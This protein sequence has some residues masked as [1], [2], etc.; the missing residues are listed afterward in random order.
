MLEQRIRVFSESLARTVDRR[1]FL[2]RTGSSIAAGVAALAMGSVLTKSQAFAE[3]KQPVLSPTI[4]CAPP[5]PYC[6]TGGGDTSGCHGGH[7]FQHLYQGN[8]VSCRVYYTFYTTGCWTNPSGSG[9][10][11]WTCCDCECFNTSG[12]RVATCGCAE[13]TPGM[14]PIEI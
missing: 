9:N 7:C 5:G 4:S 3:T 12:Q 8:V 11:Y 13:Y 10:N 14:N 6:N 2:R 1:T